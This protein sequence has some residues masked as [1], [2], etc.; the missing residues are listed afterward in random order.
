MNLVK[1]PRTFHLPWSEGRTSDDKVLLTDDI[2]VGK[3]VVV[4][5]KMDGENTT[6][7][8]DNIHARS[9][10]S[11]NHSS[12]NWIKSFWGGIKHDIPANWRICGENVYA[13]HAIAY[14]SLESYFYGFSIWDDNQCMSWDD[15]V[16]Y[17]TM[18]DIPSVPVLYS[19]I[20][21]RDII[22][23]LWNGTD[24][25]KH[26]GYVIRTANGFDY[27]DFAQC[28]AKYVRKGHV[29]DGD[30]HW[31]HREIVPNVLKR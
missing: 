13:Q 18:L 4:T 7:Y 17:F 5:E 22:M 25:N 31:M 3:Q 16:A 11:R 24:Q 15:T 30:E 14:D 20:Y 12:R 23:N 21:D 8:S 28:V 27:D 19:G 26:E 6:M 29:A 10:D 9:L 1:Y 2:F